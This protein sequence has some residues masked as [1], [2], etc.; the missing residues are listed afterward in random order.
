V[1]RSYSSSFS[2]PAPI[3]PVVVGVPEGVDERQIDGKID[4]GA[5]IC[6]LPEDLIVEL[7]LP[8]VRVVRAA[9]FGQPHQDVLLYHCALRFAGHEFPHVETLATKRPYALIGRNILR[10]LVVTLDGPKGLLTIPTRP[11]RRRRR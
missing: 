1:K 11:I 2:P 5:D 10:H 8:P 4:S 7:D 3:V 6:A 9:G